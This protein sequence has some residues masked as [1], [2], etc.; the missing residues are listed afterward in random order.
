VLLHSTKP[1]FVVISGFFIALKKCCKN[2]VMEKME[3]P[4]FERSN[5]KTLFGL[6]EFENNLF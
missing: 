1:E 4:G 2:I 6:I 5:L 3:L